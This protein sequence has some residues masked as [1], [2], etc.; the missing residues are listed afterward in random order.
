MLK[1]VQICCHQNL[2][3]SQNHAYQPSIMPI[4]HHDDQPSYLSAIMPFIHD[5]NL[6]PYPIRKSN[7]RIANVCP[8]VSLSVSK[9][10]QPLRIITISHYAYQP[11]CSSTI[12]T[13]MPIQ[14]SFTLHPLPP[15]SCSAIIPIIHCA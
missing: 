11:S 2:S 3:A 6:P 14:P 12:K 7:S 13:I 10:T 9:T 8:F 1:M 15:L 4:N 5:A